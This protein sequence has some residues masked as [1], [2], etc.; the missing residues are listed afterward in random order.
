MPIVRRKSS[1]TTR[2]RVRRAAALLAALVLGYRA[3]TSSA[4]TVPAPQPGPSITRGEPREQVALLAAEGPSAG[5][6]RS[7]GEVESPNE[8]YDAESFRHA[9]EGEEPDG[10]GDPQ[11]PGEDSGDSTSSPPHA[12]GE[13]EVE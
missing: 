3:P 12:D 10:D 7:P 2:R 8:I 13:T 4:A 1:W 6:H 5:V 9:A 11:E